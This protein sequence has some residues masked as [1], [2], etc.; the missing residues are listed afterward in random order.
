MVIWGGR[1]DF[2]FGTGGRYDPA[3]DQ[4]EPTSTVRAPAARKEHTALWTGR[5]MLLWGGRSG[6]SGQFLDTGGRYDPVRN[7]WLQTSAEQAPSGRASHTAVWTGTMMVVWG[8]SS[9]DG[10]LNTG[11]RYALDPAQDADRDGYGSCQDDCRDSDPNVNPGMLDLCN[12]I[13]DDCSG[14]VDD[15]GNALCDDGNS[16][17]RDVCGG[18][19]GCSNAPTNCDD[20][21]ACTTDSCSAA[22]GCVHAAVCPNDNNKCNGEEFCVDGSCQ[23]STPPDCNDGD[24][25]TR[26][27][28]LRATGC[29]ND[30]AICTQVDFAPSASQVAPG[31]RKDDG[32]VFSSSTGIGWDVSVGTRARGSAR[33]LELDTF[34]FTAV[35]RTWSAEVANGDYEVCV[36]AGDPSY[37]QGPH[38]IAVNG[39]N[40]IEDARSRAGEFVS[41]CPVGSPAS[42]IP[43]RNGRLQVA[44]GG[45]TGNTMINYLR[46]GLASGSV[47][48]VL[49]F[50]FQP[51]PADSPTT[52]VGFFADQGAVFAELPPRPAYGWDAP[53]QSR[54]RGKTAVPQVLDTFV[55]SSAVRTWEVSL[56]NGTYDVWYGLGDAI[57]AQ[58]PHRLVVEGTVAENAATTAAGQFIEKK[59]RV[60]VADGRLTIRIGGVGGANTTLNYIVVASLPVVP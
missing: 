11:G 5:A 26:D 32:S 49:S 21:D 59:T 53:V 41:S 16:C 58:G 56:P 47:P 13:D 55:F 10:Q 44:I 22:T 25:C 27:D 7:T 9:L 39:V 43:V 38:R 30:L 35:E 40:L 60:N 52:P 23:R 28:C 24:V 19:A 17:T 15:T 1:G 33:R 45:T 37:A 54:E 42:N 29:K 46:A 4:W 31:F 12:A 57:Y 2:D 3:T 48:F 51:Q 50:N 34:A 18:S 6:D 14:T 36:E 20:G 8:G